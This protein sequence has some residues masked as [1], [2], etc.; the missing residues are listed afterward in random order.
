MIRKPCLISLLA[1]FATMTASTT[2]SATDIFD[3]DDTKSSNGKCDIHIQDF[4]NYGQQKYDSLSRYDYLE[5]LDIRL[6]H[7]GRGKCQG[8]LNFARGT[9]NGRLTGPGGDDLK[10]LLL[11]AYNNSGVIFNPETE[12]SNSL[13]VNLRSGESV[14]LKPY[15][16][17]QRRQSGQSG[18]YSVPI[19]AVFTGRKSSE[20]RRKSINLQAKIKASVQ[21]N[22]TGVQH[23]PG[24][25]RTSLLN[26]GH[27]KA[28]QTERLGLQLRSNSDV[29][30]T[31]SSRHNGAMKNLN[32]E[33]EFLNYDMTIGGNEIDLSSRDSV[34][35]GTSVSRNG[36]T[37]PIEVTLENFDKAAAGY[38]FDVIELRVSA[39]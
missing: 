31:L 11:S 7:K 8:V 12:Q 24:K 22:F 21:A 33:G 13:R 25:S 10:F 38:Y 15:F 6:T 16:Y 39:R 5:P 18:V 32:Y 2:A 1:A 3:M 14:R 28:G 20:T 27:M 4:T 9:G 17:I 35:L 29:D 36:V 23:L 26:F 30:V 34:T 37:A 19:D